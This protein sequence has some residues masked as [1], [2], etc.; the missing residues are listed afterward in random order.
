MAALDNYISGILPLWRKGST[1]IEVAR[2]STLLTAG[3]FT[4]GESINSAGC[5]GAEFRSKIEL[6]CLGYSLSATI[7]HGREERKKLYRGRT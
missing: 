3:A 6:S 5:S 7:T 2:P 1:N 4:V